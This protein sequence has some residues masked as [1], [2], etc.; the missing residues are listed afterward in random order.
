MEILWSKYLQPNGPDV[1]PFAVHPNQD[2]LWAGNKVVRLSSGESL[3]EVNR[4][5]LCGSE[6]SNSKVAWVGA[7]RVV[8]VVTMEKAG[9][10]GRDALEIRSLMLWNAQT[11][12]PVTNV[13]AL[14]ARAL[15]VSPDAQHIAEAGEDKRVRIRNSKTLAVEQD[16]RVHDSEVNGVVWHPTLPLIATT[17]NDAT[18]RIWNLSDFHMVQEFRLRGRGED[19]RLS[20]DGRSL[21]LK[22]GSEILRFEPEAFQR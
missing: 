10:A 11:G 17:S 16:A 15:C 8:E 22:A 3:V 1:K 2:L 19:L 5:G 20:P 21:S 18:L 6:E 14:R 12:Q 9:E 7:D 13:P 4:R